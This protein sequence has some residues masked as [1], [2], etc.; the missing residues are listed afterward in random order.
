MSK[1]APDPPDPLVCPS[2][3]MFPRVVHHNHELFNN[4]QS[5]AYSLLYRVRNCQKFFWDSTIS[6]S[7]DSCHAHF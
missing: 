7:V 2:S 6:G 4:F 3:S 1:Q 5:I